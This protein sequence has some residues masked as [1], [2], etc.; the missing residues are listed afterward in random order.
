MV[1]LGIT[2]TSLCQFQFH[3]CLI[4]ITAMDNNF[5]PQQTNIL[6][7]YYYNKKFQLL[8]TKEN[9]GIDVNCRIHMV[10]KGGNITQ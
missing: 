5:K 1:I 3:F 9:C 6:S 2:E 7:P 8:W 4:L 10:N